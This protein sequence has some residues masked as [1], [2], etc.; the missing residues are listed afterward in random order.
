M[1]GKDVSFNDTCASCR[2]NLRPRSHTWITP[3]DF[4]NEPPPE[5][6]QC[7]SLRSL[8]IARR[9][10]SIEND[11]Y[12]FAFVEGLHRFLQDVRGGYLSCITQGSGSGLVVHDLRKKWAFVSRTREVAV[13]CVFKRCN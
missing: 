4:A 11:D 7:P 12:A 10:K 1:I 2:S 5:F 3:F 6:V 13:T 9:H 8:G